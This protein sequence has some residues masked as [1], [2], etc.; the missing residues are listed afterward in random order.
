MCCTGHKKIAIWHHHT[1]LSGYV[2]GTKACIDSRKKLVKQ[3]YLLHMSVNF[4][5]L[6]TEICW[7]VWGTPLNFSVTAWHSSSGRQPNFAALNRGATYI[8]QGSPYGIG[9]TIIFSSCFFLLSFFFFFISSPN[10]SGQRLDVYHTST[11]GVALV[12]I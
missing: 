9:Q 12:R 10:L 6:T 8:R 1:N 7:R 5:L 4:S 11:H 3:Q 2:F